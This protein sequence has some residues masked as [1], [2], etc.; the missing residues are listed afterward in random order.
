MNQGSDRL[1]WGIV[2]AFA[3]LI[4]GILIGLMVTM[5]VIDVRREP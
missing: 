4:A 2:G 5:V 1:L 3:G